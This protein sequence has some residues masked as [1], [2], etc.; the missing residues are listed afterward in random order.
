MVTKTL[1][2]TAAIFVFSIQVAHAS[3]LELSSAEAVMAGTGCVPTRGSASVDT[4][5]L[6]NGSDVSVIATGL[7]LSLGI[8]SG[9]QLADRKS[10]SIRI[11]AELG[12]HQR[13]SGIHEALTFG[14][15]KSRG[16]HAAIS[17]STAI[18]NA[19]VDPLTIV[20]ERGRRAHVGTRRIERHRSVEN[21]E[22][23]DSRSIMRIN[24][25][26]T[27]QL[28]SEYDFIDLASD[29]GDLR[30]DAHVVMA[31]CR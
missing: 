3:H 10:C 27:G 21:N 2:A 16:A 25:L 4:E 6:V 29:N 5:I 15:Y 26:T 23:T 20:F 22:C 12:L 18:G 17:A 13:V 1:K 7:N 19:S 11:P 8:V 31:S 28:E 30:Y 24:L 14:L 9:G